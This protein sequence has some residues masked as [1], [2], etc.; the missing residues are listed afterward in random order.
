MRQTLSFLLDTPTFRPEGS[1]WVFQ[2]R[3]ATASETLY[4]GWTSL[5]LLG[6]TE[7]QFSGQAGDTDLGS[8]CLSQVTAGRLEAKKELR[9]FRAAVF[10]YS[11]EGGEPAP[12]P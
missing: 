2:R 8:G 12:A 10:W 11:G 9:V 6:K 1:L 4:L 3:Q 7:E 5:S